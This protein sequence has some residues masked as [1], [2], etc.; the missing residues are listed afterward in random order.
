[1]ELATLIPSINIAGDDDL[2]RIGQKLSA[3]SAYS[4]ADLKADAGLRADCVKQAT[5]ILAT[6]GECYKQA[7]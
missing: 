7:A 4:T 2:T 5:A 6:I 1:L 3:M